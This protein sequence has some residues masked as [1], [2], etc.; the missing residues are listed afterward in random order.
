M[1]LW[2]GGFGVAL[3][4][5]LAEYALR[6]ELA[7]RG[8]VAALLAAGAHSSPWA[9]GCAVGFVAL[10]LFVWVALPAIAGAVMTRKGV[11]F[12]ISISYAR[13]AARRAERALSS[14]GPMG[15]GGRQ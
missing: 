11:S 2:V 8:L 4:L 3:G 10:R 14:A 6:S 15:S 7:A 5:V 12:V 9:I 1:R 13:R